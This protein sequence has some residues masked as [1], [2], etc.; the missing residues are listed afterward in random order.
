VAERD[1]RFAA[2][3]LRPDFPYREPTSQ[4]ESAAVPYAW[5]PDGLTDD[6][7]ELAAA[8]RA[9][10]RREFLTT[11]GIS[12]AN[13]AIATRPAVRRPVGAHPAAPAAAV[14]MDADPRRPR[15][16]SG[17]VPRLVDKDPRPRPTAGAPDQPVSGA[18]EEILRRV[19]EATGTDRGGGVRDRWDG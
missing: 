4:G 19:R 1:R 17:I 11:T 12:G 6:P 10:L 7:R 8:A 9:H 2:S 13:F 3:C 16:A 14:R 15:S 5:T 18:R